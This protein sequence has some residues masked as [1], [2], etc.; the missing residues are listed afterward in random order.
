MQACLVFSGT[1]LSEVV[2]GQ[3]IH[4]ILMP[5]IFFLWGCLKD[6]M[7]NSKPRMEAE[8]KENNLREIANIHA[9]CL[10]RVNQNVI[11]WCEECL[12]VVEEHFRSLNCNYFTPNVIGQQA[13]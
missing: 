12:C 8:L 7:Y 11:C 4:H 6:Q 5:V 9:V 2:F 1:E 10:Q 3:H 13:Y